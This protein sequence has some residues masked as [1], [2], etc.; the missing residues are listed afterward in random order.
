MATSDA[1]LSL[2]SGP[3]RRGIWLLPIAGIVPTLIFTLWMA[4][5]NPDIA[6]DPKGAA[7]AALSVLGLG[8]GVVYLLATIAL[9]FG[10]FAL[11]AWLAAGRT[12]GVA[13]T[14]LVLSVVSVGLLLAGLGAFTLASAVAADV[15]RSGDAGASQ[16][17]AKLSGG[18][19]GAAILVTLIAAMILGLAGAICF[20]VAIWRAGTL[21]K[22]AG[23]LVAAGF[24]LLVV[25]AP[26]VSQLGGILLAIGGVW[27]AR[28]IGRADAT[29]MA[30]TATTA[31]A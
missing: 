20:G 26:F 10:L 8:G 5:P 2:P 13:L 7:D 16:V 27:I 19:F 11:Y 23:V 3:I 9:L 17:L 6:K 22:W 21:P 25:S 4:G 14:G 28:T 15:Y 1:Y 30:T 31:P 12:G 24:V 18:N 29:G